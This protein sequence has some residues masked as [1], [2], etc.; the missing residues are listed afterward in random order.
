[1]NVSFNSG[2]LTTDETQAKSSR[3]AVAQESAPF[4]PLHDAIADAQVAPKYLYR[5][6]VRLH[7]H[8]FNTNKFCIGTL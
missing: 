8:D 1:M 5:V 7:A 3:S 2:G 4:Y 6:Q